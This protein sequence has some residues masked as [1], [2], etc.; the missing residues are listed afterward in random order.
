MAQAPA[1]P[2]WK[3]HALSL[4]ADLGLPTAALRPAPSEKAALALRTALHGAALRTRLRTRLPP[5]ARRPG[6]GPRY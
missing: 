3:R 2:K 6:P 1:T 5:H 4:A